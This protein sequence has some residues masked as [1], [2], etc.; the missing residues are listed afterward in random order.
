MSA[1]V[2]PSKPKYCV[3]FKPSIIQ[4]RCPCGLVYETYFG[5]DD[6]DERAAEVEFLRREMNSLAAILAGRR[7]A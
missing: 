2:Y 7:S 6:R 4:V 5:P 3:G 1:H